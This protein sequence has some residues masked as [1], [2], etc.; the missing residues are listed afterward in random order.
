M[1]KNWWLKLYTVP[2]LI[3]I[4]KSAAICLS[5]DVVITHILSDTDG[6]GFVSYFYFLMRCF[7]NATQVNLAGNISF[8]KTHINFP[9]LNNALLKDAAI[10]SIGSII[11]FYCFLILSSLLGGSMSGHN[12]FENIFFQSI[13]LSTLSIVFYF[14]GMFQLRMSLKREL[15][16]KPESMWVRFKK[17]VCLYSAI[18]FVTFFGIALSVVFGMSLVTTSILVMMTVVISYSYDRRRV[19]LH[20][21]DEKH[22]IRTLAKQFFPAF[23]LSLIVF[24]GIS[25]INS[26]EF[27]NKNMLPYSKLV[28]MEVWSGFSPELDLATFKELSVVADDTDWSILYRKAP[29][30]LGE[31][32]VEE[33]ILK[34]KPAQLEAYIYY[35]KPSGRNLEYISDH[36]IGNI[37]HWKNDYKAKRFIS[38]LTEKCKQCWVADIDKSLLSEKTGYKWPK[39]IVIDR[40]DIASEPE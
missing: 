34:M 11:I 21:R 20:L 30:N 15:A 8:H 1:K 16:F 5:L 25:T 38:T 27:K 7:K 18:L 13:S 32:P 22:E 17:F 23:M 2:S 28:S 9:E 24:F 31:I 39:N 40:R 36:M 37:D 10:F 19:L 6:L 26:H 33:V 12:L 3:D 35:A 4:S 14:F 29:Q